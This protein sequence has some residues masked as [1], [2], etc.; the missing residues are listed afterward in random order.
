MSACVSPQGTDSFALCV[1][2]GRH[3]VQKRYVTAGV[4]KHDKL[5][6]TEV[7]LMTAIVCMRKSVG[8]AGWFRTV[9][10]WCVIGRVVDEELLTV[11]FWSPVWSIA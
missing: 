5:V 11:G 2:G 8:T 10:K 7:W 3:I 1:G 4:L 9:K 6:T